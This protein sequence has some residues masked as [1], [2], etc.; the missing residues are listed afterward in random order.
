MENV[1]ERYFNGS[2]SVEFKGIYN[3]KGHKLKIEIDIDSY[4]SQSSAK[5]FIFNKQELKWNYLDSI[6]YSQM[7]SIDVH[8]YR[9]VKNN[10]DGLYPMELL[11]I[12]KDIRYLKNKARQI[13]E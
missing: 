1:E 2:Q 3:Y 13:L 9:K 8:C 12:E 10:G 6:H 7:E 11:S 5:C 4:N